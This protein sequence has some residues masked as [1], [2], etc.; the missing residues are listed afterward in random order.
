MRH[1]SSS[2][3]DIR[4]G[5]TM[6]LIAGAALP[7]PPTALLTLGLACPSSSVSNTNAPMIDCSSSPPSPNQ[8]ISIM[9]CIINSIRRR[10][11]CIIPQR[12]AI[13]RRI[14]PERQST[15]RC[16]WWQIKWITFVIHIIMIIKVITPPWHIHVV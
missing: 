3:F 11:F 5:A 2:G 15:A 4:F 7:A 13:V 9:F 8:C 6:G 14:I 12:H 1:E 16:A 10:M